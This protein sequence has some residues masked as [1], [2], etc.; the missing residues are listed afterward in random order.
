[1][2]LFK[3]KRIV[4]VDLLRVIGVIGVILI[5]VVSNTINTFGGLNNNSHIFYVFIHYFSS[6]AVPLFV[7][8]SGMM[9][10]SKDVI[11]YKDM[12]KKYLL[13]I[14]LIILVIGSLMILMEEVFINKDISINLVKKVFIRLITGDI[15]AHMW[16]LYLVLGLYLITPIC[17]VITN[18]IKDR[19]FKIFLVILFLVSIIVPSLSKILDIKLSFNMLNI[20]GYIFYYFYGYYLYKFSIK[21]EYKVCNYILAIIAT[22]Y[23]IY[24]AITINS[25]D[26]V[27]SY[28]FIVPCIIA[29]AVV[30][31]CKGRNIKKDKLINLIAVNSLGIY[32]IHQLFI[33]IIYKVIKFDIIVNYP[34]IGLIIYS[35]VILLLSLITTYLLRKSSFIRKYFL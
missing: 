29:S 18:N 15:W 25:L 14:I 7:M 16:Y 24:R 8:I 11:S 22:L 1:M 32:I 9:F 35:L 31:L 27:Y 28:T 6:F 21:K 10:L 33:N 17:Q 30:L 34:Y 4:W 23:T 2:E 26:N 20:S 19:E 13:K 3:K 5:H 12:F